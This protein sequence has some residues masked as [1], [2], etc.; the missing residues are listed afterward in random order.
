MTGF[1]DY[2]KCALDEL[3]QFHEKRGLGKAAK[4]SLRRLTKALETA[5]DN[6]TFTKLFDLPAE[7]RCRI[8]HFYVAAFPAELSSPSQPPLARTS[9]ALRNEVLPILFDMTRFK[10]DV[11][12]FWR[13][14]NFH[15]KFPAFTYQFLASL[16]PRNLSQISRFSMSCPSMLTITV[17]LNNV[18]KTW[19]VGYERRG[20]NE[21]IVAKGE[22]IQKSVDE[23]LNAGDNPSVA[24]PL[25]LDVLYKIR[26]Q[27]E[28]VLEPRQ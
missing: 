22:I 24:A 13:N 15:C 21:E 5:D 28:E 4:L 27:A 9:T 18:T 25:K 12:G 17:Q 8:Y 10:L 26:R 11:H 3:R 14:G 20:G 19:A 6:I 1:L 7:L 2:I 23:L 16:E